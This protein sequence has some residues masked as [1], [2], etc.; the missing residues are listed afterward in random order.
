M[1]KLMIE[2]YGNRCVVVNNNMEPDEHP[3]NVRFLRDVEGWLGVQMI[4]LKSN[5][6]SD[7]DDVF[8]KTRYMA[9]V[10]GARC[11][12][13]LKKVPRYEFSDVADIHAFGYT[14]DE[15][16]RIALFEHNN[17]ELFLEWPLLDAGI[18][19]DDCFRILQ[20]AGIRRSAMY[21]LGFK[22]ANCF[23]CVKSTSPPYWNRTR[24]VRPDI[25]EARARRSRELGVR[26]VQITVDGKRER[27]FL[28]ELR[29]EMGKHEPEPDISCGPFCSP[30]EG[31]GEVQV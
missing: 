5:K 13:E 21:D 26:L 23:G 4:R 2:K 11:S 22:N 3:D 1:T 14:A 19:K 16:E 20:E 31:L 10:N 17:P 27:I 6:Y 24:V 25:F 7:V 12:T 15:E 18:T 9:G 29:P 30:S 8:A 28:D